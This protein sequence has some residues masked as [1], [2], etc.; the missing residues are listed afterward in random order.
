MPSTLVFDLKRYRLFTRSDIGII[1]V[2]LRHDFITKLSLLGHRSAI[3]ISPLAVVLA[4]PGVTEVLGPR[5]DKTVKRKRVFN[6]SI[7]LHLAV[8]VITCQ[9]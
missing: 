6:N 7:N 5:A 4:A 9:L 3:L 1:F 2:N 8:V